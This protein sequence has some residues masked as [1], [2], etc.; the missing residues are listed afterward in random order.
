MTF[1]AM[2]RFRVQPDR[3][4][5]FER[6]WQERESHLQGVAGFRHFALL[7]GDAP[8]DYVSHST[9]ASREAFVAWTESEA[10]AQGHRQGSLTGILAGPPQIS[11]YEAVI[12]ES[13]RA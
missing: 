7:R 2:N 5:D 3:A 12:E 4:A 11:T 1:I 9:W 13:A 6:V 10:F 8:G